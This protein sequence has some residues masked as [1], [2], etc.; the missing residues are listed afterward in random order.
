MIKS[1]TVEVKALISKK[2]NSKLRALE[3]PT[4]YIDIGKRKLLL[5]VFFNAQFIY[6]SVIWILHN[7]INNNKIKYLHERCPRLTC[8]DT[9]VNKNFNKNMKNFIKKM[10]QFPC[11]I[12][13][14][15]SLLLK[16]LKSKR[17]LSQR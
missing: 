13:T 17:L 1:F 15:N 12:A 4:P 16:C 10:D 11:S 3:R 2:A 8:N 9:C 14:P 6:C 5:I 7:R